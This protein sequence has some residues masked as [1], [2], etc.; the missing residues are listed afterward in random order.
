[1]KYKTLTINKISKI[2]TVKA[3]I[4]SIIYESVWIKRIKESEYVT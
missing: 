3:R 1:M 2:G 4:T